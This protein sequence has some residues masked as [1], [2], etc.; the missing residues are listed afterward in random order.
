MARKGKHKVRSAER[1]ANT[2][3]ILTVAHFR[4]GTIPSKFCYEGQF[5][6]ELR[7]SLCLIGWDWPMADQAAR[8]VVAEAL[9]LARAVR[10]TWA[11][12]QPASVGLEVTRDSV[13]RQCGVGLRARQVHYCST[14]CRSRWYAQFNAEAA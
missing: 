11:D 14:T 10:P 2:T 9:R 1:M 5:I 13:C 8:N 7:S 4:N 12:G 3:A 6:A